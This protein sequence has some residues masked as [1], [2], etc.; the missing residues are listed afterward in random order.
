M[1]SDYRIESQRLNRTLQMPTPRFAST[2][3]PRRTPLTRMIGLNMIA[4][5]MQ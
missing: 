1:G 4:T 3:N 2:S 5:A